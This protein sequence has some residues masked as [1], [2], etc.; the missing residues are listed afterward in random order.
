MALL[1]STLSHRRGVAD[2][3][4]WAKNSTSGSC[5]YENHIQH[6]SLCC[7][8]VGRYQLLLWLR[9]PSR[10]SVCAGYSMPVKD[11][12]LPL[13]GS[14]EGSHGGVSLHFVGYQPE[15]RAR[16]RLINASGHAIAWDGYE[17]LPFYEL[18]QR[19]AAGWEKRGVGWC[20]NG[21][22]MR[23]LRAGDSLEFDVGLLRLGPEP[24]QVGVG[25]Q[26]PPDR[27]FVTVWSAP[28]VP[29]E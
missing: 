5:L 1:I 16:M 9:S 8:T 20:G 4:H 19:G 29:H 17:R 23:Q 15:H 14:V 26:I 27:K 7:S 22:E 24:I 18:L 25:F 2:A 3:E 12:P 6:F 13:R 11:T 21:A 28:F 10:G